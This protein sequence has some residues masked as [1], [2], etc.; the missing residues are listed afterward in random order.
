MS[1][2]RIKSLENNLN[3]ARKLISVM[4]SKIAK[5]REVIDN[6]EKRIATMQVDKQSMK[7]Q[8]NNY[9]DK[10]LNDYDPEKNGDS[11]M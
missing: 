4:Q 9:R 7:Q 10:K 6:K 5:Q 2:R 1:D 3:E 8:L 11:Y